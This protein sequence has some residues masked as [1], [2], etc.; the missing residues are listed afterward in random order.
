MHASTHNFP[1]PLQLPPSERP[2]DPRRSS[3]S[4]SSSSVTPVLA[5]AHHDSVPLP[6]AVDELPQEGGAGEIG[7]LNL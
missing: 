5:L 3:S 6:L 2:A 4:S 1:R 7:G